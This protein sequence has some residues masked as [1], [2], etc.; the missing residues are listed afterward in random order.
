MVPESEKTSITSTV[1]NKV[2]HILEEFDGKFQ[3]IADRPHR[4]IEQI[5]LQTERQPL[6]T[7]ELCELLVLACQDGI[8]AGEEEKQVKRLLQNDV[9]PKL[10]YYLYEVLQQQETPL[11]KPPLEPR[12][13]TGKSP[14]QGTVIQ[15]KGKKKAS[16]RTISLLLG[17]VLLNAAIV[18]ASP[19][20]G[21][22]CR[23]VGNCQS[24]KR[25]F[26]E[27]QVKLDEARMLDPQDWNQLENQRAQIE[28]AI[29]PLTG[30]PGNAQVYPQVENIQQV[31]QKEIKIRQ[32]KI[33]I[34]EANKAHLDAIQKM[35]R[36]KNSEQETDVLK[37][38]ARLDG[39]KIFWSKAIEKQQ[40]S[41]KSSR[42]IR[43]S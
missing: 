17:L 35:E 38:C 26:G 2:D 43:P 24:Y 27:A 23:I 13:S 30:I 20:I 25:Q 11:P 28:K 14:V 8:P 32:A 3:E 36:I 33:F 39:A 5:L 12:K 6:L 4:L 21:I 31:A 7:Q 9:V 19:Y 40:A 16:V 10:K 42:K 29:E 1:N 37:N 22:L 34:E 41:N 18:I 15:N